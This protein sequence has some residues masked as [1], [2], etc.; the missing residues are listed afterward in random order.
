MK[1][2]TMHYM[3]VPYVTIDDDEN[4]LRSKIISKN[5]K[6]T[7]IINI[8]LILSFFSNFTIF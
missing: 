1:H 8:I 4:K 6:V 5:K 3:M 7:N 2:E